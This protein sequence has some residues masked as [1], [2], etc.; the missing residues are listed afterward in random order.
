MRRALEVSSDVYFYEIGGGYQDQKG[1]GI[2][3]IN[4]YMRMFGFGSSVSTPFFAGGKGVIPTPEWKEETFHEPWRIGDTYNSSIG[5]YGW[6]VTPM[7]ALIGVSLVATDGRPPEP[8]ILKKEIAIPIPDKKVPM[9]D[10]MF[11]VV[12]EGMRHSVETGTA[13]ALAISSV[14]IAAKTGTAELGT[15]KQFVNSW[16]T[17][18]FPYEHPKYAFVVLME[19]GARSNLIGAPYVARQ[20]FDWLS[21]NRPDIIAGTPSQ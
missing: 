1:L 10:H 13:S 16:I 5:Q 9:D 21:Q 4:K 8:T 17:G 15:T 7:Q 20:F 12:K 11:G 19:K 3:R 6:Q 18:F 14:K 2:E